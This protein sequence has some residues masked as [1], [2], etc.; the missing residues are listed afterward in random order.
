MIFCPERKQLKSLLQYH[1]VAGNYDGQ[2]MTQMNLVTLNTKPLFV[3][4]LPYSIEIAGL[5]N[6]A[7][8]TEIDVDQQCNAALHKIDTL[9]LPFPVNST[10]GW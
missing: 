1:L 10:S 5:G 9:L 7:R 2:T 3:E 8:V 4:V 6:S